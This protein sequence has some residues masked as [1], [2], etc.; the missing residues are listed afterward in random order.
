MATVQFDH[1]LLAWMLA[2]LVPV[3][4]WRSLKSGPTLR[5]RL[6][7]GILLAVLA[8]QLSLGIAT[9]LLK[10]PVALGTAHQAGALLLFTA[11]L[12]VNH[13]LMVPASRG[14]THAASAA[15]TPNLLNSL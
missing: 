9:L 12:W 6:A 4:W 7:C 10:V 11:A 5:T 2:V 13:E 1:R 14:Q 3:F 8:L 15:V